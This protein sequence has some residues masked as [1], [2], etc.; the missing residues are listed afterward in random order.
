MPQDHLAIN[1]AKWDSLPA[2]V[3]AIVEAALEKAALDRWTQTNLVNA[4][5]AREL[6]AKGVTLHAWSETDRRAYREEA[7]AVWQ[8]WAQRTPLAKQAFE[9]SIAFMKRIGVL[10]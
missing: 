3:E 5:V 9:S 2:D 10:A 7:Q 1:K 8:S 6:V 4:E